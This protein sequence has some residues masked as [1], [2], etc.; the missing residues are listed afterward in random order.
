MKSAREERDGVRI[1]SVWEPPSPAVPDGEWPHRA[2]PAFTPCG[3]IEVNTMRREFN[4]QVRSMALIRAKYRCQRC[5]NRERL[6]IHHVGC[7][8]DISLF[9]AEV[10][11]RECHVAEH[12]HRR[13]RGWKRNRC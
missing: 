5:G 8:V 2:R 13:M 3:C 10:L 4:S 1:W 12:L 7:S 6:E 9:N 11:C